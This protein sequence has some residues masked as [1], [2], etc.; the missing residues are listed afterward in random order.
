MGERDVG[1]EKDRGSVSEEWERERERGIT[2][3]SI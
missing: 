2:L 1:R 3:I